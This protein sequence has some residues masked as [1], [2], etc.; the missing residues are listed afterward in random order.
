MPTIGSRLMPNALP[1]MLP[2]TGAGSLHGFVVRSGLA[3]APH[4]E[5][6]IAN[7]TIFMARSVGRIYCARE[8]VAVACQARRRRRH[9][10]SSARRS[11][12][13]CSR[14]LFGRAF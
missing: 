9:E 2:L 3:E 4:A 14:L 12:R 6:T 8:R 11:R 10:R 13:Q 1:T 7:T 5:H